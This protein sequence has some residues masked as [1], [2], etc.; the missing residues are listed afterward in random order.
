M[1]ICAYFFLFLLS[2]LIFTIFAA[3]N[4]TASIFFFC[5]VKFD[6]GPNYVGV[7]ICVT[8]PFFLFSFFPYFMIYPVSNSIQ[9]MCVCASVFSFLFL[10]PQTFCDFSSVKCGPNDAG[11]CIC[12][13]C[14]L[15]LFFFFFV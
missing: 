6:A 12:V 13:T 3:S 8:F 5:S 4:L 15:F 9:I 1:C 11:V 2:P 14:F 10:F 7:C